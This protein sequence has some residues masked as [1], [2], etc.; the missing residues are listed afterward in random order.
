MELPVARNSA[1]VIELYEQTSAQLVRV[2]Q[3]K[4]GNRSEA[5]E[6]A[7]DA[8]EKLLELVDRDDI[9]DL[10]RY[11]FVM[12]NRMALKVI[13]RRV[14]ENRYLLEQEPIALN[15]VEV[16]NSPESISSQMEKLER[17]SEAL[18]KLPEQ[19]RHVFILHRFEG[20]SHAEI[21]EQLG[22]S[23]KSIEYHM[24]RG[25]S[26]LLDASEGV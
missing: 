23:K 25:L 9:V 5:E 15:A 10:R 6:V 17:V 22:L 19:T 16:E 18:L 11:F 20:F 3:R 12:A 4:L 8:F 24:H 7:H 14:I 26:M 1:K 21:A 2:L 13:R